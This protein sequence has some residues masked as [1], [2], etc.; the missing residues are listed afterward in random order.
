MGAS[1][2]LTAAV[3]QRHQF[4][5]PAVLLRECG[6]KCRSRLSGSR[7]VACLPGAGLELIAYR[8]GG[9]VRLTGP[10]SGRCP[11]VAA[12]C[13][14]AL[15]PCELALGGIDDTGSVL[16]GALVG[17]HALDPVLIAL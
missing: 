8:H 3:E 1:I 11:G 15:C 16:V 7:G 17:A 6:T 13:R 10:P 12:S 4:A 14:S 9:P 2:A 5:R